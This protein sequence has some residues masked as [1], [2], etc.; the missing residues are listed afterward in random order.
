MAGARE[1]KGWT[2]V[3]GEREAVESEVVWIMEENGW[4]L[5]VQ[6]VAAGLFASVIEGRP[7]LIPGGEG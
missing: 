2:I 1:V 7:D 3:L 6:N 5:E 4:Q